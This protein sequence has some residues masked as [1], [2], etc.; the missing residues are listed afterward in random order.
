MCNFLLASTLLLA[1][2][3][4]DITPA[5]DYTLP[6][7]DPV[8]K[9]TA[10]KKV[11]EHGWYE[12]I[13]IT[14]TKDVPVTDMLK[15]IAQK[16]DLKLVFNI[17][18]V[19]GINYAAK[20]KPFI[21]ILSDICQMHDWKM[22]IKG[23]N[24]KISN[25]SV[26]M[27]TYSIPYLLGER[28]SVADTSFTGTSGHSESGSA[29]SSVNV[30]SN[31]KLSNVA[32]IDAFEELRKNIEMI[33]ATEA[34]G[35]VKFSIH[36]QAGILTV[37]AT[38]KVHKMITKYINLL[39]SQMRNQILVEARIYEITLDEAFETGVDWHRLVNF[40]LGQAQLPITM[41]KHGGQ[42]SFG[43]IKNVAD[44]LDAFEG[45]ILTFL[46][47][48]GKVH[49]MS[50]PRV[51]ITNNNFAIFKIVDNEVF[52]KLT[53][54]ST[55][56]P[57]MGKKGNQQMNTRVSSEIHTIPVG[58][59]LLV[60]PSIDEHGKITIA[61][62]P[63]ISEVHDRLEDP[64]LVI[65]ANNANIGNRKVPESKIP[66]IKTRELDTVFTT[67][68]NKISIIG[69][70]LYTKNEEAESG[71]PFGWLGSHKEKRAKKKEIVI[72][73]KAKIVYCQQNADET[74]FVE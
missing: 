16:L 57:S 9:P 12:K 56:D 14:L 61:L 24:A 50:N 22:R 31:A 74:V 26:Y 68:E 21:E 38:Q 33:A 39:S 40:G 29:A 15:S 49:S 63:T 27:H 20:N 59:T 43:L 60:Q 72:A 3:D 1:G 2:C 18:D 44:N 70:L 51:M 8:S 4:D 58:V 64:A 23:K 25:D 66:V 62:H 41:T 10:P 48:F 19:E 13:N 30:G 36:K 53:Q 11:L 65:M 34:E 46:R 17:Q 47:T 73:I 55:F 32:T 28:K 5:I 52:F 45:S 67:E 71:F 42:F 7:E 6:K 54:H 35:A 37:I 69:G